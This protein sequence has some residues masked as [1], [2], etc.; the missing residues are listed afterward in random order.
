M[1]HRRVACRT[2]ALPTRVVVP[3]KL[4][5]HHHPIEWFDLS[6]LVCNTTQHARMDGWMDGWMPQGRT[7]WEHAVQRP[8]PF[9][10]I[11]VF[12]PSKQ[13]FFRFVVEEEEE[14]ENETLDAVILHHSR[15]IVPIILSSSKVL[16]ASQ[17]LVPALA[18]KQCQPE[19]SSSSS[20]NNN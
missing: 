4:V 15:S 3:S 14:E 9:S 8:T 17:T 6:D 16:F 5:T 7:V 10:T 2:V 20:Y 13:S 19:S 12:G 1:L 18:H 11:V